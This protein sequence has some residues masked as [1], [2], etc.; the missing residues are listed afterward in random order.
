MSKVLFLTATEAKA[1]KSVISLGVMQLLLR[2]LRKVAF[3]RPIITT[4][5][6]ETIKD[7]DIELIRKHFELSQPYESTFAFT[8]DQ[9][10]QLIGQGRKEELL[11]TILKKYKSLEA[12]YDFILCEGS[13]YFGS[14][15]P[16]EFEIN[17]D[18]ADIL[19]APVLLIANGTGK[20]AQEAYD[21][22]QNTVDILSERTIKVLACIV[23]RSTL[24]LNEIITASK[25]FNIHA[26]YA[27]HIPL[28][29]IPEEPILGQPTLRDV[30][31]WL[32]A[33][34]LTGKDRMDNNVES[35]LVAAMNVGNFLEHLIGDNQ[36]IITPGDRGDIIL[37][38]MAARFSDAYPSPAGI[39][40]TGGLDMH[41]SIM[42]LAEGRDGMPIMAVNDNTIMC[43]N[44]LNRLYS[45]LD[46]TDTR[47]MNLALGLFESSVDIQSLTKS[48][49]DT[50]AVK[51]SPKMFEFNL[52]ERAARHK[53]RIVLPE[54]VEERIL[55]ATES[56][57]R[58]NVAEVI[59]L[60]NIEEIQHKIN[61]LGLN[62]ETTIIQP[63]LSPNF[64]D[65]AQTYAELRKKKGITIEQARDIMDDPTYFGT[66][67]VYKDDADGMVSGC[68][69]TTAHTIRPA[70]EFIKTKPTTSIVS[71]VFLMCMKD[72]VL[73][74]GDCAVNPNPTA[75]QLANIAVSSAQTAQVFGIEP[76][77]AML[78]YSTG[79]SGKGADVDLVLDAT[80]LAQEMAPEMAIEGPLQYDAAIDAEVA[81]TKMPDSKVAGKATVFIFPD[82]NTGNNTYKAVQRAANAVAIGPVLQGLNKPVNDLSRGCTV[83]DI[84][85][86]VAIT[87]IQAQAEKNLQ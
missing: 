38:S 7:H 27:E 19:G 82:L 80:K 36:L 45:H 83:P 74:F 61:S 20:N 24:T 62:F 15:A 43:V 79:A 12:E 17:A 8:M 57:V 86:T 50:T 59:L 63:D 55:L 11:D 64:E 67:M 81:K 29:F 68:I 75:E 35:N 32:E 70:F 44:K 30:Q 39:V 1:G 40:L 13:D 26:P 72:R 33:T 85:N 66:M 76:R 3:F 6:D 84:I 25:H 4:P 5:Q 28:H 71:S 22:T 9:A 69:N 42:R 49:V 31:R 10:R 77:V 16:F 23:N 34:I 14:D 41:P 56:L 73:A 65:Y 18:I 37:A 60:G 47:R 58:R 53:M 21:S 78:S 87:A 54:G 2:N 52:L 48:L 51:I 46:P